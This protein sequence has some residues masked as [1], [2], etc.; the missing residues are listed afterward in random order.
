MATSPRSTLSEVGLACVA[1]G[2]GRQ[3]VHDTIDGAAGFHFHA[4]VG[5]SFRE[6][7]ALFDVRGASEALVARAAARVTDAMMLEQR[8]ASVPI[9]LTPL[10][11]HALDCSG[12][13]ASTTS[14]QDGDSEVCKSSPAAIDCGCARSAR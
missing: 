14:G 12:L 1:L 6:G 2:G 11:L 8:E 4:K 10:V 9:S 7:D 5:E 3:S 13:F